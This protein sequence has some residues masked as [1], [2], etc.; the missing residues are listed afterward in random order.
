MSASPFGQLELPGPC[1]G[2]DLTA[3]LLLCLH[4]WDTNFQQSWVEA[5][6]QCMQMVHLLYS[7]LYTRYIPCI[8]MR[9]C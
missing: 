5:P 2:L 6:A 1:N 9:L 4:S 8:N 3:V 7:G